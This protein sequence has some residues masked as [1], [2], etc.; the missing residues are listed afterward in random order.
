MKIWAITNQKG[1]VGKTTTAVSLGGLLSSQGFKTLLIDLDPHGSLTSYFKLDPDNIALS[2]YN[3]FYETAKKNNDINPQKY[4]VKTK[5]DGLSVLPSSSA[6]ATLDKAFGAKA[7]MGLVITHSLKKISNDYDHVIIDSPPVLGLLMINALAACN[8]IIIP[9]LSEHMAL[10]G[11]ERMLQT[12]QMVF[13]SLKKN[14][15]YLIVPT[16][17]DKRTKAAQDS[18]ALL[19]QKYPENI[20]QS[21]IPVDT[22]IRDASVQ[23]IPISIFEESAKSSKAYEE[24]LIFLLAENKMT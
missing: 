19:H 24:L 4:I 1:G 10:K 6:I 2:V 9:S 17:F 15:D 18:L 8:R 23:G 16:V 13:K 14:S 22:K 3:L 11:L 21:V 12:L 5:F 20:W 7:G